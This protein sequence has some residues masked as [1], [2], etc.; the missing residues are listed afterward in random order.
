MRNEFNL[1]DLKMTTQQQRVIG[2][3]LFAVGSYLLLLILNKFFGTS[4]TTLLK[5]IG[6]WMLVQLPGLIYWL[7][8]HD[9][10]EAEN[11]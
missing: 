1:G 8:K 11:V 2:L 4:N 3:V 10:E 6:I 5:T 9:Q 7:I